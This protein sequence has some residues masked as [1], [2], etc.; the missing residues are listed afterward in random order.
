MK[1]QD[2]ITRD[3]EVF[4][5]LKEK[6]DKYSFPLY[7]DNSMRSSF[8]SCPQKFAYSY[9]ENLTTG[10]LNEHLNFGRI[11]ALGL[12]KARRAFYSE[13]HSLSESL[14]QGRYSILE[15]W[16]EYEPK[17][18]WESGSTTKTLDS[19]IA[20]LEKYLEVWPFDTDFII[21]FEVGKQQAI[22]FSFAIPLPVLHPETG[23]PILYVGRFDMLGK[24]RTK[25]LLFGVDEKTASSFGASWAKQWQLRAQFTGYC[26]A[27]THYD[28]P[29]VGM[30]IRG[31]KILKGSIDTTQVITYRE[32]WKIDRWLHQLCLD[33][34]RMIEQWKSGRW[35][36]ALDTACSQYS[37]CPFLPLCDT[38]DP[39]RWKGDYT[40]FKWDP[41]K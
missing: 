17:W 4:Q 2:R 18:S 24:Y 19:A 9:I 3:I 30:L 1:P 12:E 14:D 13:N 31:I 34:E 5:E 27:A 15:Y 10:R 6:E 29:V 26:F 8:I 22:E 11:F 23:D 33:I 7:I 20:S 41:L 16:A 21:P 25:D 36:V 38:Q 32:A 28:Y 37:G 35:A 39:S 40:H